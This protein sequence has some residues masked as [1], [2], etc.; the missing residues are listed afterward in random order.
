M[1]T[2]GGIFVRLGPL[3][4]AVVSVIDKCNDWY[5]ITRKDGSRQVE[6][7]PTLNSR[8]VLVELFR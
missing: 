7:N 3:V 2:D 5:N 6:E 1:G 8:Y 4:L